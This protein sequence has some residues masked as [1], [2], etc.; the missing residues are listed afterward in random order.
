MRKVLKNTA[1]TEKRLKKLRKLYAVCF[2]AKWTIVE[3]PWSGKYDKEDNPL[4]YI[5]FDF[6]GEF[7]EYRLMK[8]NHVSCCFYDW[9]DDRSHAECVVNMLNSKKD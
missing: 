6:N 3:V 2:W 1:R 7:D 4:V 8:I 9:Y 5:Y